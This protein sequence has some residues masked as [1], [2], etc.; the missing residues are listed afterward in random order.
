VIIFSDLHLE[1]KTREHALAVLEAI[2]EACKRHGDHHVVF[3]GDFWQIRHSLSVKLLL[4]AHD[5]LRSWAPAV[6]RCDVVPG[7]HDQVNTH[8]RNAL[9]VF[10]NIPGFH[11]H[12]EPTWTDDGFFLPW[13]HDEERAI[14]VL[15]AN[16]SQLYDAPKVLFAHL[17]V[18][19][20]WM[21]NLKKNS[22]GLTVDHLKGW[23][24]VFLGH[25]HRHQVLRKG[26]IYVGSPYET[27][28]AEAG[29]VKGYVHFHEGKAQHHQL[30]LGPRHHKVVIDADHPENAEVP[31]DLG[32]RDKLWVQVKGQVAGVLSSQVTEVLRK[33][34]VD[35]HRIEVDL[36]PTSD[37]ARLKIEP[38]A[39]FNDVAKA[40]L[41]AQD[42]TPDYKA[43]LAET[44]ERLQKC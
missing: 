29:Q 34:G 37:V 14:A 22:G 35:A 4:E 23:S 21:N 24:K 2:P 3:L 33:A 16:V 25:Y 13:Q 43:L 41:E 20:A 26:A 1:A 11:V 40:Y 19:G 36:Q 5:V 6:Q 8:G 27:N 30:D 38:G 44:Y 7:N 28:Y 18:D 42:L 10:D 9:E 12:T 32:P 39:N 15:A 17:A 31:T